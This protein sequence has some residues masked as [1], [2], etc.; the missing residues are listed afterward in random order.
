MV[1]PTDTRTEPSACRASSPVSMVTVLGPYG[2]ETMEAL[3]LDVL[4]LE[5]S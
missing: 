5:N 3:T 4:E 1:S 2:K